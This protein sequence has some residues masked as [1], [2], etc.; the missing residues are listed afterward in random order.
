MPMI[1]GIG[2]EK[3]SYQDSRHYYVRGNTEKEKDCWYIIANGA[4]KGPEVTVNQDYFSELWNSD[5][6]IHD[7]VQII[8]WIHKAC[9]CSEL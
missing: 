7:W 5:T 1:A 2:P 6:N 8:C 3:Y 9:N 4:H